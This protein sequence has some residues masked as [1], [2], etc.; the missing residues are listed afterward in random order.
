MAYTGPELPSKLES[1]IGDNSWQ[2][3]VSSTNDF[4]TDLETSGNFRICDPSTS[5]EG[6]ELVLVPDDKPTPAPVKEVVQKLIGFTGLQNLGNTC[7][8]N[9]VIQCLSNTDPFRDYFVSNQYA[10]DINKSNPLGSGGVIAR[11]FADTL[12]QL[13]AGTERSIAPH[14]LKDKMGDRCPTFSN[15]LQ[16]DAQEFC[17]FFLD[18][19][20]EDLNRVRQ[21]PTISDDNNED[22]N[23]PTDDNILADKSWHS[24]GLMNDSIV[25]QLFYGQYK[26][27]LVCPVCGKVC[28]NWSEAQLQSLC[29]RFQ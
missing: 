23:E 21:R 5:S 2:P 19:L 28:T 3:I 26:S 24:Y 22:S 12:M 25:T 29:Y 17:V 13:W 6:K 16:Q 10:S 9:S 27:K 8:M 20:H 15:Y 11:V 18:A 14:K 1:S 4:N 7:F